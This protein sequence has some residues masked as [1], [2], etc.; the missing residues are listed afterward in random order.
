MQLASQSDVQSAKNEKKMRMNGSYRMYSF[1]S[2]SE[3][4]FYCL[5]A[6]QR[7]K[8]TDFG[9][10]AGRSTNLPLNVATLFNYP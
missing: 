10:K 7:Q 4:I 5:R 9:N 2:L 6:A 8:A 1:G 3:G